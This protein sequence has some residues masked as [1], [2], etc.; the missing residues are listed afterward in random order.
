MT[1]APHR[2]AKSDLVGR[3]DRLIRALAAIKAERDRA[4][5]ELAAIKGGRD[6]RPAPDPALTALD[7]A[8]GDLF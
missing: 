3:L 4:L 1:Q 6:R 2:P 7:R 8:L 5:A